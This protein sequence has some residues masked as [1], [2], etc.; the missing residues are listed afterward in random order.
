MPFTKETLTTAY[1]LSVEEVDQTLL[2]CELP[3]DQPEY[4][5]EDIT[6]H[7]EKVRS[8]L[9]HGQAANYEAAKDLLK[10]ESQANGKR[11]KSSRGKAKSTQDG[12][13]S[14]S[15]ATGRGQILEQIQ[16][17]VKQA[18]GISAEEFVEFLP[19]LAEQRMAELTEI[20]DQGMLATLHESAESGAL[21]QMVRQGVAGKKSLSEIP[22]LFLEAEVI[23]EQPPSLPPSLN[24][25]SNN[26]SSS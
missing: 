10:Q 21:E 26:K 4:S 12:N 14:G 11:K 8:F 7:F 6:N 5:D 24:E 25:S 20:F 22:S 19:D 13:D 23:E 17:L 1:N 18:G 3:V 16:A 2:A 9:N 15:A